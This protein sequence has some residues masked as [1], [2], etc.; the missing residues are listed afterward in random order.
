MRVLA[1]LIILLFSC[2]KVVGSPSEFHLTGLQVLMQENGLPNNTL[3]EI[4]Q[5]K[6]GFLWLGTDVGISRYD[7]IHFHNWNVDYFRVHSPLTY[8]KRHQG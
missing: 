5:D 4:H 2:L 1:V 3:L 7:G 6:R 8:T